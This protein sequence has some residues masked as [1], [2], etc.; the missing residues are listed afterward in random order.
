[1]AQLHGNYMFLISRSSSVY[2][3]MAKLITLACWRGT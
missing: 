2:G 1:M 3:V